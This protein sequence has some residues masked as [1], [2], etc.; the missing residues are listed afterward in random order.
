M[1]DN[2][3]KSTEKIEIKKVTPENFDR[4][5]ELI[6][7]LAGYEKLTP[8]DDAAKSVS[9]RMHSLKIRA[10]RHTSVS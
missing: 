1:P 10:M 9:G 6:E 4:F 5:V 8:P 7:K 3:N 2:E